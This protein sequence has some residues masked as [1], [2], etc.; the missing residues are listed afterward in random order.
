MIVF[1]LIVSGITALLLISGY[2][3]GGPILRDKSYKAIFYAMN[4]SPVYEVA[5]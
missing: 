2:C 3:Y 5:S 1:E 4:V